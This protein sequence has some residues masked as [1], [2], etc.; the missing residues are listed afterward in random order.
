LDAHTAIT[1]RP[2]PPSDLVSISG[3]MLDRFVPALDVL[4]WIRAC[5]LTEHGALFSESLRH[6]N[7]AGVG[8]LWTNCE[9]SRRGRRIVGQAEATENSGGS[10]GRWRRA[11]AEQQVRDWFNG[12]PNFIIT[13][14]A[15]FAEQA[16]DAAFCALVFHE[17][18]HCGQAQDEFGSPK[19]DKITGKPK[20]CM[21]A[22]DVEQFTEVIEFYGVEAAGQ[23]AVDFVVAAA[24]PPRISRAKID[25]ACGTCKLRLVA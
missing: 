24:Q 4:E 18:L 1:T 23:G 16:D 19:F 2:K 12:T 25:A 5:Y 13:L 6:L 8:I 22:H 10:Q 11:R 20:F 21:R 14:D 17:L 15:V 7:D 3:M 9:N